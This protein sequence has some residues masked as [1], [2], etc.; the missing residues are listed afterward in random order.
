MLTEI[1]DE[2]IAFVEECDSRFKESTDVE[3]PD[4]N[5]RLLIYQTLLGAWPLDDRP[6]DTFRER[7]RE[8]LLKALREA[9]LHTSWSKINEAYEHAALA[10][11]DSLLGSGTFAVHSRD[12]RQRVALCGA[13][14][15]L[16]QLVWK[17]GAPGVPDFYQGTETWFLA[18]VDPDNRR[19]ADYD[20]GTRRV[21]DRRSVRE[22]L[23]R[24]QDGAIKAAVTR[25]GLAVRNA[26]PDL[27]RKGAYLPLQAIGSRAAHAVAFARSSGDATAVFAAA[28]WYATLCRSG[29][30]DPAVW[31]DTALDVPPI[32]GRWRNVLTGASV[33]AA[34]GERTRVRLAELFDQLPF[35]ILV[36]ER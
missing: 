35:A 31:D 9:K 36:S 33:S 17:L 20:L 21:R 5:E 8:F 29:L 18:L 7:V 10:W 12:I 1:A 19:P 23:E 11:C 13:L 14:N 25:A 15:S 2:W 6:D 32:T 26:W 3:A 24:W 27:F 30:P 28:R 4:L 16:S 22:K 34:P